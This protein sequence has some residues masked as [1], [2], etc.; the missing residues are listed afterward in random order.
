MSNPTHTPTAN[1]GDVIRPGATVR[2]L[3]HGSA[4]WTVERDRHSGVI[5]EERD[6][7]E[8][9]WTAW[10]PFARTWRGITAQ[11]T[12]AEEAVDTI[13][14]TLPALASTLAES[15][16]ASTG[17][18]LEEAAALDAV[19][20]GQGRGGV[21]LPTV[22]EGDAELTGPAV[23][24]VLE[25]LAARTTETSA[26]E[27]AAE[28]D[29]ETALREEAAALFVVLSHDGQAHSFQAVHARGG[30]RPIAW[31]YRTGYGHGVRFGWVLA[32][33]RLRTEHP[34][35][36]Y[37][38]QAEEDA[39]STVLTLTARGEGRATVV[40]ALARTPLAELREALDRLRSRDARTPGT[41]PQHVVD[42]NVGAALEVLAGAHL[43]EVPRDFNQRADVG[44]DDHDPSVTGLVVEPAGIGGV[45]AYWVESGL[46]RTPGGGEFTAQLRDIRRKFEEAGWDV[47]PGTRRVVTAYRP[48]A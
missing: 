18:V 11:T 39:A 23:L 10:S 22:L 24:E 31:T 36:V 29:E 42:A 34:K 12:D 30:A 28:S 13:L 48:T 3:E 46:Y 41:R 20:K 9:R 17:D 6:G 35:D 40:D 16:G 4:Q 27:P 15:V 37:R 1:P 5:F 33:G 47:V 45:T 7:E 43:A 44:A 14:A 32:G 38:W 25:S 8:T 21:F 26:Q 19:W 2:R